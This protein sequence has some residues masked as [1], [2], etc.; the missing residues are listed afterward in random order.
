M[1]VLRRGRT[2]NL[3]NCGA[4]SATLLDGKLFLVDKE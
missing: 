3:D 1:E 2:Q 4:V